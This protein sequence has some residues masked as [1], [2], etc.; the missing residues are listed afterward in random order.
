MNLKEAA[1]RLGVHYQT[2]YR[3]VRSGD[4]AAV[5]VGARY[6][7]SDAAIHQFVATRASRS[8]DRPSRSRVR[9]AAPPTIPT[10]VLQDLEAMA[11]D[12]LDQHS[13][14]HRV[15]RPARPRGARRPLPRRRHPSR[16]ARIDRAALDHLARRPRRVRRRR[17]SASPGP[18]RPGWARCWRRC[19][20]EGAVV[21]DPAR[22]PGPAARRTPTRAAPV[23]RRPSRDRAARRARSR[24]AATVRGMV[25]FSRDTPADPYTEDDEEFVVAFAERVGALVVAARRDRRR[26]GPSASA[27]ADRFR[28]LARR[29][30][31]RTRRSTRRPSQALLDGDEDPTLAVGGLRPRRAHHRRQR[32]R[33]AHRRLRAGRAHRPHLRRRRRPRRRR[34]RAGE[35]RPP[36]ER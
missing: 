30:A 32:G 14:A 13:R 6:E 5:R 8:C 17:R 11:G 28:R 34:D 23:P 21:R 12:P 2:A 31:A 3:W 10:S 15:R 33:R 16:T 36:R 29:R 35:L 25:V 22:P 27:L 4:L 20:T 26:P 24:S 19:S 1:A 18:R 9:R 7:V